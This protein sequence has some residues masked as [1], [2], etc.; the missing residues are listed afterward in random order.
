MVTLEYTAHVGA[1]ETPPLSPQALKDTQHK[2][3]T[4]DKDDLTYW[5]KL[6]EFFI[7]GLYPK[8]LLTN[9]EKI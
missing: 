1:T 3:G 9:K 8:R 7:S 4:K 5:A 2:F 6:R